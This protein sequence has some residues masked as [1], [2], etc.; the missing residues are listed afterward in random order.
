MPVRIEIGPRDMS[1]QE[2]VACR[3]DNGAKT[4]FPEAQSVAKV[5]ELLDQ[6]QNDMFAR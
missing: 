6:V 4:T 2:F 5:T 1:K 3:R